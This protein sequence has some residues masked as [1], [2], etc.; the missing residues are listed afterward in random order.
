MV[1]SG[2]ITEHTE[3]MTSTGM[4]IHSVLLDE[5]MALKSAI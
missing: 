5:Q 3:L 2:T 4:P 1:Y